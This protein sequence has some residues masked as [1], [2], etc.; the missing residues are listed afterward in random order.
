LIELIERTAG[1]Q[2]QSILDKV[3]STGILNAG[4]IQPF[5]FFPLHLFSKNDWYLF[6]L[7]EFIGLS[8]TPD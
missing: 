8:A 6:N 7:H 4:F 5:D 1:F 2:S 3:R